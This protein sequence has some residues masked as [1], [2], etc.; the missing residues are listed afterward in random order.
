M[1]DTARKSTFRTGLNQKIENYLGCAYYK[2][3]QLER[4]DK[5]F[6]EME[7]NVK[8]FE[9]EFNY[10]DVRRSLAEA[11]VILQ[12]ESEN[13]TIEYNPVKT[14]EHKAK[15]IKPKVNRGQLTQKPKKKAF[16]FDY[17]IAGTAACVVGVAMI[18][19]LGRKRA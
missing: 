18:L 10:D 11:M 3:D 1:T 19:G 6:S 4:L 7:S 5:I 8:R 13:I 17:I 2:E 12:N 9:T 15:V 16:D 14:I